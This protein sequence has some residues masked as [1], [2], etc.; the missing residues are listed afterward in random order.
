[1]AIWF[2]FLIVRTFVVAWYV[3]IVNVPQMLE[4]SILLFSVHVS[5]V[6]QG[7]DTVPNC[8]FPQSP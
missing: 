7:T 8:S 6:A 4:K 3:V 5:E 2:L 1:M